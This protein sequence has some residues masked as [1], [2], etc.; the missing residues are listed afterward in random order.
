MLAGYKE[1]KGEQRA[2]KEW[3]GGSVKVRK[4]GGERQKSVRH[5]LVNHVGV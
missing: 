3:L 2:A 1:R 4:R 5:S